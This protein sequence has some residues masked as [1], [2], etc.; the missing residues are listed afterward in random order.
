MSEK[1]LP[2]VGKPYSTG[3]GFAMW[4]PALTTLS[5]V[6]CG[7][8]VD[9]VVSAP[10]CNTLFFAFTPAQRDEL[11]ALLMAAAPAN[12]GECATETVANQ[13]V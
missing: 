3:D 10:G 4:R 12:T 13:G 6:P 11:V 8:G 5:V 1:S 9:I 7:Q 2:E